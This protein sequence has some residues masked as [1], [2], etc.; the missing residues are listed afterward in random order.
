MDHYR[1]DRMG[2]HAIAVAAQVMQTRFGGAL[3][4]FVAGSIMRGQGTFGSDIDMVVLFPRLQR[5]WRES[6][7]ADGFPIEAFV[8]DPITLEVFLL[9]DVESGRPVM[10]NMVAEGRI[11]GSQ[12]E[13][14]SGLKAK[15]A[16]LLRAGPAPLAGERLETLLYLVSDLAD[17]L[18]GQR[19]REEIVAIAATLYPK[20]IDLW[21]LGRG[22]W[23]G[24]GKWLP[25]RLRAVDAAAADQLEGAMAEA[26]AGDGRTLLT[27][28][29]RELER[30]GG[31][32]FAGFRRIS[33]VEGMAG[34]VD[35][36]L[37]I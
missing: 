29:E 17:D 15:A 34:A 6:F 21:L 2:N 9:R 7:M 13:G 33:D 14:A 25:R 12:V 20:L 5:A 37:P 36:A 3:F 24:A 22:R 1:S 23:T 26:A 30:H 11:V 18:R 31:A 27:L 19:S 10:I 35:G 8:H 32:V 16:S 4:A 28:C